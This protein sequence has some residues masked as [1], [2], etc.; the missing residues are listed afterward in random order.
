MRAAT[1][2]VDWTRG[3]RR[4][5]RWYDGMLRWM[6]FTPGKST[7]YEDVSTLAGHQQ[8]R[9]AERERFTYVGRGGY[10]YSPYEA[11]NYEMLLKYFVQVLASVCLS[12]CQPF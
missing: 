8:S 3:A 12:V 4:E 6:G 1:H 7:R 5:P 9:A 10:F 2:S 11:R